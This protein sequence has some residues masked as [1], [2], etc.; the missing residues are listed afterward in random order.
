[1]SAPK[2]TPVPLSSDWYGMIAIRRTM[3]GYEIAGSNSNYI[4]PAQR[5]TFEQLDSLLDAVEDWTAM[6]KPAPKK[7]AT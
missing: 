3:N 4:D 6:P 5:L 7:D 1:M 2:R